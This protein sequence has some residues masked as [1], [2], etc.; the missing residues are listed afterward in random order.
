MPDRGSDFLMVERNQWK[1]YKWLIVVEPDEQIPHRFSFVVHSVSRHT[2]T[3]N[4]EGCRLLAKQGEVWQLTHRL[5]NGER[6]KRSK[7]ML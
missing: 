5:E 2:Y 6:V 3:K 1:G 7:Y 4:I